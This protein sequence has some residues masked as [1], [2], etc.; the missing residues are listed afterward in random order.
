MM[1]E[2]LGLIGLL[3]LIATPAF[4][5][6]AVYLEMPR[7]AIARMAALSIRL[8]GKARVRVQIKA[9]A[10]Q[11]SMT[12][13]LVTKVD[14]MTLVETLDSMGYT[15]MA[16]GRYLDEWLVVEEPAFTI[17]VYSLS[18]DPADFIASFGIR[19]QHKTNRLTLSLW[20]DK[21]EER[22]INAHY[23]RVGGG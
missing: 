14:L 6:A 19:E 23:A 1:M 17:S 22:L 2:H 3:L 9:G 5:A 12:T 15:L 13:L 21:L 20:L 8:F 11:G 18:E 4:F 10:G 7:R 16:M